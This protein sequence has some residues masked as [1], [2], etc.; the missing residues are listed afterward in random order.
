MWKTP[1]VNEN[2][3]MQIDMKTTQETESFCKE[4]LQIKKS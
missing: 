1:V 4:N 2:Q 3:S